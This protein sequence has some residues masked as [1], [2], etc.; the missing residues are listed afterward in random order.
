[1]RNL[2]LLCFIL[3]SSLNASAQEALTTRTETPDVA[4]GIL[5]HQVY[6]WLEHPDSVEDQAALLQGLE[7]LRDIPGVLFLVT[8][9][10]APTLARDVI[11]SDWSVSEMI[12]FPSV[13][14][15]DAYQSHPIHL[16]FI[17]NYQHL[18]KKVVVYDGI[19]TP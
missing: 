16:A 19:T 17:E 12:Q 6:F 9:T 8:C 18:W 13:E 14:A 4:P 5:I 11:V 2:L 1:M 7:T 10:P 3:A 15:Q